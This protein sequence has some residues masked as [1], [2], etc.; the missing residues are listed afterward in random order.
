MERLEGQDLR[1]VLQSGPLSVTRVLDL[2]EQVGEVLACQEAFGIVHRDIKPGNVWVRHDGNFC[3]FDYGLVDAVTEDAVEESA[4][5]FETRFGTI[6]GTPAY[7]PPEIVQ[8]ISGDHRTDLFLLGMT[9]WHALLG[10]PPREAMSTRQL[11]E[12]TSE[13][14]PSPRCFVRGLDPEV[15][16]IV[17]GLVALDPDKRYKTARALVDD[18][19]RCRSSNRP[20]GPS[21]GSLFVALPFRSTFES[22]FNAI[23]AAATSTMLEA[24]RMDQLHHSQDVWART[25]HEIGFAQV[26]VADFTRRFW[27]RHP[28]PNVLTDA[29]HAR[30]LGKP[31]I[32]ITRNKAEQLPFDWRTLPAIQYRHSPEGYA[33]LARQL[34]E[35]IRSVTTSRDPK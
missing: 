8:G 13:P 15:E 19:H 16:S 31:L 24:R 6:L 30:A 14:I 35:R 17:T 29:A 26:V 28:N 4:D 33:K 2:L 5:V 1:G 20:K 18:V 12:S 27:Q 10:R 7:L 9:A 23:E 34:A 21:V 22:T 11:M 32:L 25:A 3:L